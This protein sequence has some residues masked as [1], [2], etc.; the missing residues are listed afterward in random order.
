M[1]KGLVRMAVKCTK[2]ISYWKGA[3]VSTA[4]R[5]HSDRGLPCQDFSRAEIKS[6]TKIIVVSDG[7]GSARHAEHGA[8]DAARATIRTLEM[9]KPWSDPRDVRQ[10]ILAAC[11]LEI[12]KRAS[13][14]GCEESDLAS[15]LVFVAIAHDVFI[16][17]N[18]GDGLVA[19]FRGESSEIMLRPARGEFA[20]ET[21]FITSQ[22]ANKHFYI[23]RGPLSDRDG[24]AV[25]SDGTVESLYS[26]KDA[27]L[28]PALTK[29]L[30]WFE[31][32]ASGKVEGAIRNNAMPMITRRT[33]DDCSLAALKLVRVASDRF[34]TKN[35]DF[36]AELLGTKN[37]RGLQ[38]RLNVFECIYKK[39]IVDDTKIAQSVGFSIHTV[40]R[41]RRFLESQF[42]ESF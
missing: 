7:A 4:G 38:N 9:T 28:A 11:K 16:A 12:A 20:N 25:M 26:K 8:A 34:D 10:R 41:H 29:I 19:T 5:G 37:R 39:G 24:F 2:F 30:S 15:T 13:A 23:E 35:S 31:Q 40:R 32:E 1:G 18:L 14:L 17:G 3:S 27:S 42:K 33:S 21:T 36:Q 6:D 22:N